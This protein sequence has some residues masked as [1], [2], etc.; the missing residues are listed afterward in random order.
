MHTWQ[1]MLKTVRQLF[2]IKSVSQ[3]I[4]KE[5]KTKQ[6]KQHLIV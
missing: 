1:K 4:F 5:K 6:K 2:L 3:A